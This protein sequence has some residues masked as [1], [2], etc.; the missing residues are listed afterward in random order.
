ML[1]LTVQEESRIIPDSGGEPTILSRCCPGCLRENGRETVLT[2]TEAT[3]NGSVFNKVS[4]EGN[5]V[6]I[7][8]SGALQSVMCFRPGEEGKTVITVPPLTLPLS[9]RCISL[10]ASKTP[11]GFSLHLVFHASPG[12]EGQITELSLTTRMEE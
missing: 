11:G 4:L 3:E 1:K 2:Y 10:S 8:R 5:G 9:Y 12:G 6:R 7:V